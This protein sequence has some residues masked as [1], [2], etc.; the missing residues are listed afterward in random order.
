[1]NSRFSTHPKSDYIEYQKYRFP[2][3]M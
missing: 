1:M 2:W 3:G